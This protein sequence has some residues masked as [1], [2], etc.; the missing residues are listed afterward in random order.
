M[1]V[2]STRV[3]RSRCLTGSR[4]SDLLTATDCRREPCS[5]LPHA[6]QGSVLLPEFCVVF[7]CCPGAA[8][9]FCCNRGA[10]SRCARADALPGQRNHSGDVH[11]DG[12]RRLAVCCCCDR[13]PGQAARWEQDLQDSIAAQHTGEAVLVVHCAPHPNPFHAAIDEQFPS[14]NSTDKVSWPTRTAR[15]MSGSARLCPKLLIRPIE[16]RP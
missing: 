14:V 1:D 6:H 12:R 5:D 13:L 2:R 11:E 16:C 8:T 3:K 9:T 4:P 15:S 7:R 10:Q